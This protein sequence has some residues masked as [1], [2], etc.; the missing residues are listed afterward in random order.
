MSPAVAGARRALVVEDEILVAIYIEDLLTDLGFEVVALATDLDQALPVARE[1]AF[2]VAVLDVNLNGR[3]SFPVA[4]VLRERRI[5]FLFASGY[6]SRG[7]LERWRD[8]VRIQKPFRGEDLAAA[9]R[10]ATG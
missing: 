9:I 7:L 10:R 2:D 4:E 8:A 1:G 3:A 6:G 5:P